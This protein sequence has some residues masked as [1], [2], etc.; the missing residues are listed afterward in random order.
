MAIP[1]KACII[2]K[3]TVILILIICSPHKCYIEQTA[4]VSRQMQVVFLDLMQHETLNH[5]IITVNQKP[6][7]SMIMP[8]QPESTSR[9]NFQ[10]KLTSKLLKCVCTF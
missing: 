4:R 5:K 3:P 9:I 6:G 1:Y 10:E 2:L 8:L 7:N